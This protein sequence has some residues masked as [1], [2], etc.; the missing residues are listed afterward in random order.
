M[1]IFKIISKWMLSGHQSRKKSTGNFRNDAKWSFKLKIIVFYNAGIYFISGGMDKMHGMKNEHENIH[2]YE[3][4]KKI[5][6]WR[7]WVF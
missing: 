5:I 2:Y 6:S 1:N 3:V 4:Q 7:D